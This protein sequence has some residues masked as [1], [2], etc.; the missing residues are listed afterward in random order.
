MSASASDDPSPIAGPAAHRVAQRLATRERLLAVCVAEFRRRG[1][2]E[3]DVAAIVKA[4]GVSRGSFYFHFPT[5]EAVLAELRLREERRIAAEVAPLLARERPLATVLKAVV[6]GI[7]QAEET[8]GPDILR[9]M[10]AVQFRPDVVDADS[11]N[12]H[13]V[14]EV[15]LQAVEAAASSKRNQS[16]QVRRAG[17]AAVLFL[18]G[19]FGLL[20]TSNGPSAER[21]RLILSL[22]SLTALGVEGS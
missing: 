20:S 7:L 22:I 9:E 13:P 16:R 5:K 17:D 12:D 4:A 11:P 3:T 8:L 21:D 15:V 14:A 1:Y 2:A 19:I 6:A 18:I 10:C